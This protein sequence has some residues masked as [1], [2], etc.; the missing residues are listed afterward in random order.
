MSIKVTKSFYFY[1][2]VKKNYH[3]PLLYVIF[4]S[5]KKQE[6]I[7]KRFFTVLSLVVAMSSVASASC[8]DVEFPC[9]VADMWDE[10]CLPIAD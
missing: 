3:F 1:L 8:G 6:F 7:M 10:V 9:E 4:I 5:T 2:K